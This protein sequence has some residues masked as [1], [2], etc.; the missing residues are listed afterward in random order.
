MY[1]KQYIS[2]KCLKIL[3]LS[4]IVWIIFSFLAYY[5]KLIKNEDCSFVI[6]DYT[7]TIMA[8]TGIANSLLTIYFIKLLNIFFDFDNLDENTYNN[9]LKSLES[10]TIF[11]ILF[12]IFSG[13]VS[14]V[15]FIKSDIFYSKNIGCNT[16]NSN[17]TFILS[18]AYVLWIG[19]ISITIFFI[20]LISILC[21]TLY[22]L[23]KYSF[24]SESTIQPIQQN[25]DKEIQVDNSAII[26]INCLEN[27]PYLCLTCIENNIDIICEP[28]HHI[29]I[30]SKCIKQL[31][32]YNCPYC[33]IKITGIKSIYVCGIENV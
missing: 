26:P 29:C 15:E 7:Q 13:I 11:I 32:N 27:K 33:N 2:R 24:F 20:I 22:K 28:C 19:I 3:F 21:K 1:T 30:C 16:E 8:L 23:I 4:I 17:Y 10:I 12:Y 6:K 25:N 18:M 31:N 5:E 14:F 9:K